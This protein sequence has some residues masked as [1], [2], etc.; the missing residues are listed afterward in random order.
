MECI[1]CLY[2]ADRSIGVGKQVSV[3]VKSERRRFKRRS[4]GE[5]R[6]A[7]RDLEIRSLSDEKNARDEGGFS[8]EGGQHVSARSVRSRHQGHEHEV[9]RL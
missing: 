5:S 8:D 7:S 6:G 2:A 4:N 1:T 3:V 9:T